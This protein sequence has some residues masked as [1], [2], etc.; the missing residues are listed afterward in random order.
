M[1]NTPPYLKARLHSSR[2]SN[3]ADMLGELTE[4]WWRCSQDAEMVQ[5]GRTSDEASESPTGTEKAAS[6]YQYSD[7]PKRHPAALLM[8]I[9]ALLCNW[10]DVTWIK[11]IVIQKK[12]S[13]ELQSTEVEGGIRMKAGSS[14][15]RAATSLLFTDKPRW[16]FTLGC[17]RWF[18]SAYVYIYLIKTYLFLKYRVLFTLLLTQ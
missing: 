9:P 11:P 12:Q 3:K 13:H 14:L 5:N 18:V 16:L 15:N 2:S 6:Q 8:S 4:G 10:V 17:C 1:L 7:E